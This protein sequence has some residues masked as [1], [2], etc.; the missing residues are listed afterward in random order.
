[1]GPHGETLLEAARKRPRDERLSLLRE[2]LTEFA[3][4]EGLSVLPAPGGGYFWAYH[5][6]HLASAPPPAD[7]AEL[8]R[9]LDTLDDSVDARD[10]IAE[11]RRQEPSS[12]PES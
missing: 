1:M 11:L 6:P 7:P 12:S 4:P 5:S 8:R 9:R 10:F 3:A 2:L